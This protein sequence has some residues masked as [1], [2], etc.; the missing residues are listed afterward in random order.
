MHGRVASHTA[1]GALSGG[2]EAGHLSCTT[3]RRARASGWTDGAR[4]GSS[5]G[6][7][8]AAAS[9]TSRVGRRG[10]RAQPKG[11]DEY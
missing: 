11:R 4:R 7:G 5:F 8:C 9:A 10:T 1:G 2:L 6:C 3:L